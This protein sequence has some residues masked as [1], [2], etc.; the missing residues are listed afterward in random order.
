MTKAISTSQS[1]CSLSRGMI[2]PSFGPQS[3]VD[4]LLKTIGENQTRL[5]AANG[6]KSKQFHRS[7]TFILEFIFQFFQINPTPICRGL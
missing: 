7:P 2:N 1:V 4:A 3:D 6:A 5:F